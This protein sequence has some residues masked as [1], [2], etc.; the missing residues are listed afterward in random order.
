MVKTRKAGGILVDHDIVNRE[1]RGIIVGAAGA[2]TVI[3]D[4]SDT[5]VI[6]NWWR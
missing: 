4:G 2:G 6:G 3:G 5:L 1:R